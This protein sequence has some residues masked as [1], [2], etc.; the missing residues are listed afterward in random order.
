[1]N[2][3]ISVIVPVYNVEQYLEECI[4]SLINQTMQDIEIIL[5][6]DG[7]S[8]N[9]GLI[10]DCFEKKYSNITAIHQKNGGLS[11]ARNQG[12]SIAKGEYISFIDSDDFINVRMLE[13]LYNACITNHT[14]MSACNYFYIKDNNVQYETETNKV[15]KLSSVELMKNIF[16]PGNGIGVFAWNKLYHRSLLEEKPF[17]EG[18]LYEDMGSIYK[19]IFAAEYISFVDSGLYYYRKFRKGA[20]TTY[21]YSEKEFDRIGFIDEMTEFIRKNAPEIYMDSIN[22]KYEI[23]YLPVLNNMILSNVYDSKMYKKVRNEIIKNRRYIATGNL[24]FIKK[25]RLFICALNFRVYRLL[26]K[27]GKTLRMVLLNGNEHSYL[28]K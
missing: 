18:K 15:F 3:K 24:S 9:C 8:D 5:I 27:A 1:M 10:C 2:P 12:L 23:V 20:I 28:S 6:D 25:L 21:A 22:Y 11:Y 17:P 14:K 4:E 19:M 16:S 26:Y 7:S 13:V